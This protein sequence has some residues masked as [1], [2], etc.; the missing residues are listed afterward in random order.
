MVSASIKGIARGRVG[1]WFYRWLPRTQT[2]LVTRGDGRRFY[3]LTVH[4]T[5]DGFE[6]WVLPDGRKYLYPLTQGRFGSA[7]LAF[8]DWADVVLPPTRHSIHEARTEGQ[9]E[10]IATW[11]VYK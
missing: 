6:V 11:A 10:G 4:R 1:G 8:A 9:R 7:M 2:L 5:A 3:D